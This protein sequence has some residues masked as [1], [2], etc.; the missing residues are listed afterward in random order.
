MQLTK[1]M[2]QCDL[3]QQFL[4]LQD[5]KLNNSQFK[6]Q[7]EDKEDHKERGMRSARKVRVVEVTWR[8][9]KFPRLKFPPRSVTTTVH[10]R[11]AKTKKI[12]HQTH[13]WGY[14]QLRGL[15]IVIMQNL[16][17]FKS[18]FARA[19]CVQ[20]VEKDLRPTECPRL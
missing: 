18:N 20:N 15:Y 4:Q 3:R 19:G 2:E 5:K 8:G 10:H 11:V 1:K 16:A 14:P 6:R 13:T 12:F 9:T 7:K 17:H